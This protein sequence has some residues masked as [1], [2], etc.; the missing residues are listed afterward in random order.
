MDPMDFDDLTGNLAGESADDTLAGG[1]QS[2]AGRLFPEP[3]QKAYDLLDASRD[4][5]TIREQFDSMFGAGKAEAYLSRG[6][7]P[8]ETQVKESG[9]ADRLGEAHALNDAQAA[10]DERDEKSVSIFEQAW[11]HLE[12]NHAR[13]NEMLP[14]YAQTPDGP[15]FQDMG[16]LDAEGQA[17]WI[18]GERSDAEQWESYYRGWYDRLAGREL[19]GDDT[20]V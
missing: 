7:T 11:G 2:D 14:E 3:S 15:V 8:L 17:A 6:D 13:A 10:L 18:A 4:D 5:P 20:M 9:I 16:K 12:R 19:D 1:E